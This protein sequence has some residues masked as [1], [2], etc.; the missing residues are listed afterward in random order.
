MVRITIARI[1]VSPFSKSTIKRGGVEGPK[2]PIDESAQSVG[3]HRLHKIYTDKDLARFTP[4]QL[5]LELKA[6]GY[7]GK[8]VFKEY[9]VKEHVINLETYN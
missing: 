2:K 3:D 9:I 8:L 4:R 5:V 1:V 7:E 6:R